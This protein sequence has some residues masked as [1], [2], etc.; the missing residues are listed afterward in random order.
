[1]WSE[2]PTDSRVPPPVAP[3]QIQHRELNQQY[4]VVERRKIDTCYNDCACSGLQG[5]W[6]AQDLGGPFVHS[7]HAT[8]CFSME[9]YCVSDCECICFFCRTFGFSLF[10]FPRAVCSLK[11]PE[12]G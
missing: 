8:V 3:K 9:C 1:M 12:L 6:L 5:N 4:D 7:G 10:S 11:L 2:N